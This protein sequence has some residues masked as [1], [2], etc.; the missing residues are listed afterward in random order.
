[1]GIEHK[2]NNRCMMKLTGKLDYLEMPA[3]GG[4]LDRVKA[5]Y[6]RRLFMVVHRLWADLFGLW[7]RA[8][9]RLSGRCRRSA[10][11]AAAG[12]LF[13]GSGRNPGRRRKCRRHDRQ[14][15]LFIPRRQAVPFRRPGRQ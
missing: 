2:E 3:T 1:M 12:A 7:R 4:T 9:R 10:G 14:A 8:R 5:F 13:R 6:R 15:D 11:E